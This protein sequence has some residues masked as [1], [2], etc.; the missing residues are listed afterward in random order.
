M[1]L[2][3]ENARAEGSGAGR[4]ESEASREL[5]TH[6]GDHAAEPAYATPSFDA[7]ETMGIA[8]YEL[9]PLGGRKK[10]PKDKGWLQRRYDPQQ[11]IRDARE[12]GGNVGVRLRPIDLVIDVDP[13]NGGDESLAR[14]VA[15]TGL[16]LSACPHVSTGG[17]GHHYYLRKRAGVATVSALPKIY[18][19]IDFKKFGGQV[20]APGS[21]HP[22]TGR[23]YEAE[24]FLVQPSETPDAC[25][26]LIELLRVRRL[27]S[28]SDVDEADRW[29]EI[30]PEQLADALVNVAPDDF[31]QGAHDDWFQLMCACHHAT[32]GA[33]REEFI[34][35][36]TQAS[37]YEDDAEKI[38]MRWDSLSNAG[39]SGGKPTTI[40]HLYQVLA[41]YGTS[42][43]H[44]A[45]EDD[46]E[47]VPLQPQASVPPSLQPLAKEWVWVADA[48]MFIRRRDLKR[49]TAD[50]WR[51][52]HE[53]LV[54]KSILTTVWKSPDFVPKFESL[55]YRPNAPEIIGDK[56]G[57][58]YNIWRPS[59]VKPV[60]GNVSWFLE[61]MEYLIPDERE[62][63]AV[64]D[65]LAH[66][67]QRKR[68]AVAS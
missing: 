63:D 3:K 49:Y 27:Q 30:S 50:Q 7:A 45:P 58:T 51:T 32:A 57:K 6:R 10:T 67:V 53:Y 34:T 20:V 40:R 36:S 43:P 52:L 56:R 24:F 17:G 4:E 62:R 25:E 55:T 23:H 47:P 48:S 21:V 8:G 11:V 46:F 65:Y 61:H 15:D 66:L 68:L 37:G 9:I 26:A 44:P 38:G 18:P 19:G 14:L 35:W 42:V 28:P 12:S 1:D 33:G 59:G 29:G 41:R 54:D 5:I 16:N 39:A 2:Q 31:G 22:D 13:R 64:L 60:A